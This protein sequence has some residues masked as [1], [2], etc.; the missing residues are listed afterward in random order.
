[1]ALDANPAKTSRNSG[2]RNFMV[3]SRLRLGITLERARSEMDVIAPGYSDGAGA[4]AMHVLG[5]VLRRG[6]KLTSMGGVIGIA[7]AVLA[8]IRSR[9]CGRSK[10]KYPHSSSAAHDK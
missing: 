10:A 2:A 9:H 7:G 3:Y 6:L 5:L 8:S 4:G 1:M